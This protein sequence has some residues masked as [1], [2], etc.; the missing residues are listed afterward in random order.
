MDI[1]MTQSGV[2]ATGAPVPDFPWVRFDTGRL[3]YNEALMSGRYVGAGMSA[4]GRPMSR[5]QV[6]GRVK[7]PPEGAPWLPRA[8]WECAFRLVV[9]GQLLADR[10]EWVAAAER[11][12]PKSNCREHVV[13]LRHGLRPVEVKVCTRL[14]DTPFFARWLEIRNTGSVPA[15]L[16][17]VFPW[18]GRLWNV[19]NWVMS[20]LHGE[21]PF[22]L[23]RFQSGIWGREGELA[24]LP[25]PTGTTSFDAAYGRSGWGAPFFMARNTATGEMAVGHLAWSG[26]WTLDFLNDM[27]YHCY[28]ANCA[29]DLYLR[30][31]MSGPAPLRVLAPG[32]MAVT[33]EFH[34]GMMFGDLDACVNALHAHVR[35]SVRPEIP[36]G[37]VQ[38]VECNHTGYTLNAQ[39]TEE[40]LFREVDVAAE[41]GVELF[42]IDA[43]WYG[44]ATRSWYEQVGDWEETPLLKGGLKGAFDRIRQRGMKCGLWVEAERMAPTSKTAQAHP[45]WYMR[46]RGQA[47]H[48]LDLAKPEVELHVENTIVRLVERYELDCFRIDHN[49]MMNEG[50]EIEVQG[51]DG[52]VCFAEN[53]MWRYFDALYRILDRIHARFPRLL[54]ENCAGGGGRM[55]LGLMGR[56]HWTQVSD[57]WTPQNT[58]KIVNGMSLALPPEQVMTILGAISAG[59]SDLDFML[60]IG[61]FGQFCVSGIYPGPGETHVESSARWKHAIGIYKEFVRPFLPTSRIFHHTPQLNQKCAGEW[62]VLELAAADA[63]RDCIGVW[64]L[65]EAQGDGLQVRPRGLDVSRRYRV[66]YDNTNAQ[67]VVDGGELADCGVWVPV[68][69]AGMSELLRFEVVA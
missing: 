57:N 59:V 40:G 22:L 48:L 24:W 15:V 21:Q 53:A 1:I 4:M 37:V 63:G 45:D 51:S 9:D 64:R 68:G 38:P 46:R 26:N 10:W 55:D 5:A 52:R 19:G 29:A 32:E 58:I 20:P 2:Q 16:S 54:L 34:L 25:L 13:T 27:D 3:I 14:D 23:G 17:E 43:G 42:L 61:M 6:H 69:A 8:A 30:A 65:P 7:P 33:P 44:D 62:C 47:V 11:P 12:S 60:R 35:R 50:G 41:I 67:R 39:I 56:F 49:F 31:G 66:T 36:A 18:A 28:G